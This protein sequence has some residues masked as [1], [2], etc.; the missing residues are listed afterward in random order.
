MIY[1]TSGRGVY[2]SS[3]MNAR[4]LAVTETNIAFRTSD[5]LRVQ[6]EDFVV[7]I[8]IVLSNNHTSKGVKGVFFDICDELQG[9]YPKD[10]KFTGWHPHCRCHTETILKTEAEID[11]DF[12]KLLNG[13]PV[14]GN[15]VNAVANT[16]SNFNKWIKDNEGRIA[17]AKSIPYFI[18]DNF[19]DG[20]ISN[21]YIWEN[22]TFQF[23]KKAIATAA[24]ARHKNRDKNDI[25]QRWSES[26]PIASISG[27]KNYA[28]LKRRAE[29]GISEI[30][31]QPF[32]LNINKQHV[33]LEQAKEIT[34]QF[35]KLHSKYNTAQGVPVIELY[36][37]NDAKKYGFQKVWINQRSQSVVKRIIQTGS[38][39]DNSRLL[40]VATDKSLCDASNLQISTITHEFGHAIS[41]GSNAKFW[42]E[43][44]VVKN[45]Y[46]KEISSGQMVNYLGKYAATNDKEFVAECFQE[47]I[48]KKTPSKYASLVGVIIDKY[49]LKH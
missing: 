10:F 44:K 28:E 43:I 19:K 2:R 16:P 36:L 30:I 4:R 41:V 18:K 3:Y 8:K 5:Y 7:G 32:T 39:V 45:A 27:A 40:N 6:D 14:N 33:T 29:W 31:G 15:S 1:T 34:I 24:I 20:K 22:E 49:Y 26:H 17:S 42:D 11:A 47:Y 48:N 25:I 21:G 23:D 12:E 35:A 46:M 38:Y 9:K 13:Q 37:K